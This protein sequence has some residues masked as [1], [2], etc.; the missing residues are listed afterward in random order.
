MTFFSIILNKRP[1]ILVFSK[2]ANEIAQEKVSKSIEY[3][4]TSV[5]EKE[6][7]LAKIISVNGINKIILL[8]TYCHCKVIIYIMINVNISN[9]N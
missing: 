4:L 7:L 3:V 9:I 6:Y 8:R 1:E 2:I 5:T